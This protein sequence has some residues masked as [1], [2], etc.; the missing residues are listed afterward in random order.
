MSLTNDDRLAVGIL[1]RA[2]NE[3]NPQLLD[4]VLTDDWRDTPLAPGQQPGREGL[5]PMMAALS[6]AF[7]NLKFE[8]QEITGQDGRAGVRL[9][10]SGR[11]TG[12]WMGVAATGKSF[13]IAWFEFHHTKAGRIT[14]TWHLEDWA[15]WRRQIGVADQ[16]S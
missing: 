13:S 3:G 14:H 7:A 16:A 6:A 12:E 9:A 8:P 10:F 15:D 5:K 4:N 2:F 11:H 1:Y